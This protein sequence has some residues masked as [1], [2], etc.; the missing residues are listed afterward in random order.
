MKLAASALLAR[1]FVIALAAFLFALLV[2]QAGAAQSDPLVG[3]WKLNIAKST[4]SPGSAPRSSTVRYEAIAQGLRATNDIVDAQGKPA[5]GVFTIIHDG[6]SH[7]VTGVPDYDS[8]AFKRIDANTV[9]YT[10]MNTGR[11]V[12]TGARVLSPDGR[13]LTFTARGVNA[14]G[15]Q[16][17]DTYVY[18]RQ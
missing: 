10:R 5:Q 9:E 2:P 8:S 1:V 7:P 6:Q 3:T 12:Q 18:D 16:I 17:N 14:Q 4:F 13:T 15:Q 11:V